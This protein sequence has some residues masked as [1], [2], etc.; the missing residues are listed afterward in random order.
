MRT[1]AACVAVLLLS[2]IIAGMSALPV[3]LAGGQEIPLDERAQWFRHDRFG[4]FIITT[5]HHDGFPKPLEFRVA[6]DGRPASKNVLGQTVEVSGAGQ[7]LVGKIT[8]GG[9]AVEG[10]L[11]LP[12]GKQSISVK[13]LDAQR[14]G[15][16]VLDLFAMSLEPAK[17]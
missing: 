5:K 10:T 14:T 11:K 8:A 7:K 12:A 13:L 15:P 1:P 17:R 16:P 9:V 6:I 2:F 4:I 3:R